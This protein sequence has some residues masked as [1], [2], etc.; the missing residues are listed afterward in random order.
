MSSILRFFGTG[1]DVVI[2]ELVGE[3][4]R[5]C[6]F[7]LS[8]PVMLAADGKS[9]VSLGDLMRHLPP[10]CPPLDLWLWQLGKWRE[11]SSISWVG[12]LVRL[13]MMFGGD[14]WSVWGDV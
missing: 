10:R 7:L 1:V 14:G 11:R 2:D 9:G 5:V 4:V 3:G 8:S 13:V 12:G 6:H